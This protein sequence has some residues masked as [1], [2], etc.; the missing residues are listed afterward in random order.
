MSD[1]IKIIHFLHPVVDVSAQGS[2]TVTPINPTTLTAAGGVLPIGTEN[3]MIWCNCSDDYGTVFTTVRWHDPGGILVDRIGP[4]DDI[5]STPYF[6]RP[7]DHN[8]NRNVILVIPT[9][10]DSYDGNY[11]CG[12]RRSGRLVQP[13]VTVNLTISGELFNII[14]YI[15][16][17]HKL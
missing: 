7:S 14:W 8:N 11:T 15:T 13:I 6:T 2:C 12:R 5:P 4:G 9:F 16:F 1:Y 10:S 17:I 3:V